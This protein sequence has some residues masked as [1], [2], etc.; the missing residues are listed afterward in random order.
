MAARLTS[1][2]TSFWQQVGGAGDLARKALA[3]VYRQ[4]L[5]FGPSTALTPATLAFFNMP[6]VED[7]LHALTARNSAS[8]FE[9]RFIHPKM[10]G[11]ARV[12]FDVAE[13]GDAIAREIVITHGTALG[14]HALLAARKVGIAHEPFHLVLVGGVLRHGSHGISLLRDEILAH[15]KK[16]VPGVQIAP[17]VFE[18]VVGA[19]M[20][21]LESLA[22][23][24]DTPVRTQLQHTLPPAHLFKTH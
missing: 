17:H 1:A 2:A 4:E 11:L 16:L 7:V 8:E 22:I 21:A 24:I 12:L 5:G 3:A 14:D 19:V 10:G 20:L 9:S 13:A 6:R 18:P 15:V 23:I